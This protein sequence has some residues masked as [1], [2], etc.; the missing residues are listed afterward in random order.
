MAPSCEGAFLSTQIAS[1]A[2]DQN[3]LSQR[4]LDSCA[5][6]VEKS[7]IHEATLKDRVALVRAR[8]M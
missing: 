6:F 3:S 4:A 1:F 2:S 8:I 5:E 7:T